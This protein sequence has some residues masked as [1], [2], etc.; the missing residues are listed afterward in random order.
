MMNHPMRRWLSLLA[1]VAMSGSTA[2]CGQAHAP[3]QLNQSQQEAGPTTSAAAGDAARPDARDSGLDANTPQH[4]RDAASSEIRDTGPDANTRQPAAES[5]STARC[6][7]AAPADRSACDVPDG[8]ALACS[9]PKD[10]GMV[11]CVCTSNSGTG[12]PSAWNCQL[13]VSGEGPPITTC[14]QTKPQPGAACAEGGRSCAYAAPSPVLC[15]CDINNRTWSCEGP[16]G[17]P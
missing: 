9:Y 8:S 15:Q 11:G 13:E 5:S 6:P 14:P 3:T 1:L 17:G 7:D 10:A 4:T 2:E 16:R 12:T